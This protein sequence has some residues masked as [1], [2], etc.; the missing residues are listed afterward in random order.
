MKI[1]DLELGRVEIPWQAPSPDQSVVNSF[2]FLRVRTDEGVT[3]YGFPRW[4]NREVVERLRPALIGRD[5]LAIEPLSE[6]GG[7]LTQQSFFG[8]R[9]WAIEHAL[10]DISGKA[11][12]LPISKLLGGHKDR[13]RSYLTTVWP[14]M[15]DDQ[16]PE[17]HARVAEF[18]RD[19]G[20][21]GL[22]QRAHRSRPSDDLR[23]VERMRDRVGDD[24][25]IMIDATRAGRHWNAPPIF[26]KPLVPWSRAT[27]LEMA[28]GFEA[29]GVTW[30]EEPLP[31]DDLD[32]Y[33]ALCDAVDIPITG[34]EHEQGLVRFREFLMRRAF[35]IVQP[36]PELSGG[37]WTT[38]KIAVAAEAFNVPCVLH[39][40]SGPLLAPTLQLT[41]AISN[42]DWV[43]IAI[44]PAGMLPA[45]VHAPLAEVMVD[46]RPMFE[47][48]GGDALIPQGPGMGIDLDE[49][50]LERYRVE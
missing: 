26:P 9:M 41:G 5:P 16:D 39:G 11:A 10:W 13:V 17:D 40:A 46:S 2:W 20:F 28:R 43:E 27:A 29:L 32:G 7:L 50:R 8:P 38:R 44:V 47:W 4:G 3:G 15:E 36:D 49:Q 35:D 45:E 34:G 24:F 42:C 37:V 23:V 33:A 31:L 19:A 48:E 22:K 21:Q 1:I 18:I 30:L 14:G 12:S 6:W 25:H